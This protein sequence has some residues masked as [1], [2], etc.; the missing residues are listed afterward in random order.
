MA[1]SLE[2]IQKSKPDFK[3][4]NKFEKEKVLRPWETFDQ[5]GTQTR[6]IAAKEAVRKAQIIV[7]KNS[8]MIKDLKEQF[9]K[10]LNK[11]HRNAPSK[12]INRSKEKQIRQTIKNDIF[13]AT[14][15]NSLEKLKEQMIDSKNKII[16]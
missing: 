14:N 7:Q 1:I 15:S 11:R 2:Q 13:F 4:T 3:K 16:Q 5:L 12:I 8:Q 6:T 9:K 10:Y